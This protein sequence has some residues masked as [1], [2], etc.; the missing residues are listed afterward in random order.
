MRDGV[1][2]HDWARRREEGPDDLG[3]I[4]RISVDAP[5]GVGDLPVSWFELFR[6]L[7]RS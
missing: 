4:T 7:R 2:H 1:S 6:V 3:G 5:I